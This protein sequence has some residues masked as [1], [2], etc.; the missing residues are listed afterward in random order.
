ML[1][2]W[3]DIVVVG[4]QQH[5]VSSEAGLLAFYDVAF[6]EVYRVAARLTWG[7]RSAAEDL[8]QDAF[9]RLVRS[10]RSGAVT[11]VGVG[12]MITTVRR[13]HIDG[14]RAADREQ[15]RLR[16]VPTSSSQPASTSSNEPLGMLDGLNDRERAAIIL[17]YVDDLSVAEV[18]DLMGDSLRATESLLQRAKRKVRNTRSAS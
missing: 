8:V 3:W 13:L 18:A 17:R 16:V 5:D 9:V 6:D 7:D 2:G 10:V 4:E 15:R 14:L 11:T 12:W 1:E